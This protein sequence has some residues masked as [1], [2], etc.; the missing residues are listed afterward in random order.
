MPTLSTIRCDRWDVILVPFKFA[1]TDTLKPRPAIVVS[2]SQFH[3]SR[4][5]AIMLAVTGQSGR[6][7]FG[8]CTIVDWQAAGLAMPSTAKGVLRTIER[9]L[10]R[11]YLG[12]LTPSDCQRVDQSLRL[13]MGL[14]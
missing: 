10:F 14:P 1:D 3:A 6:Q 4:A 9:S 12:S 8:D 5:D 2:V 11:R 13:I 7:Y